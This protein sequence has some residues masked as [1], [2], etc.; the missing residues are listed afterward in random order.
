[1]MFLSQTFI[2]EN[3]I[4]SKVNNVFFSNHEELNI[5][6]AC[7]VIR[8]KVQSVVIED[9]DLVRFESIDEHDAIV[10][11]SEDLVGKLTGEELHAIIAHEQGHIYYGH[12]HA[13][14]D[15]CVEGIIDNMEYEL[16]ADS[17]A[18]EKCGAVA[19]LSGMKKAITS[20]LNAAI[21]RYDV[22]E[23]MRL[24]VTKT[25]LR[26]LKPRLAVIRAAL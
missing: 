8:G 7:A 18:I 24:H 2:L 6:G 22:P 21:K 3:S 5:V 13:A 16:Q 23:S 1:M 11:L 14:A 19:L 4:M 9:D 10:L 12:I 25:A 15:D 20:T 17:F 26:A